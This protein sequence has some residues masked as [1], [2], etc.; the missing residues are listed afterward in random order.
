MT[1]TFPATDV[2][3]VAQLQQL[4]LEDPAIRILDVRTG[5]EFENS[6]IPGSYNVPLDTLGEHV[7]DLADVDHPVVLVCQSGGRASQAHEK[8]T[9]A[10]KATLH[11]LEGGMTSWQEAGGDVTVGNTTRWAMDRQVRFV[12]GIF[13]IVAV[14]ASIF[15]P[16]LE[17]IAAGVGAGLA[18]SAVS[19][20]CAMAAVLAKLPYN[21][22]NACDISGILEE[23]KA[24]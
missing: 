15:V 23:L 17:W 20:T 8:L 4:Q 11:I 10:G 3:D 14:V 2:I 16:G 5:G 21:R 12:A 24:A 19:N 1:T 13:A 18:Y 22:T 9:E 7:R 6:H